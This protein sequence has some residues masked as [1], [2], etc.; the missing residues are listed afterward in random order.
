MEPRDAG[1]FLF[2]PDQY[3]IRY[4]YPPFCQPAGFYKVTLLP[5]RDFF[6][7]SVRKDHPY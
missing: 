7:L 2:I 5:I 1:F 6:R 3:P 4:K